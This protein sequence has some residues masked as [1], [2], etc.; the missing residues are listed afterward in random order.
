MIMLTRPK[1]LPYTISE[2]CHIFDTKCAHLNYQYLSEVQLKLALC[3]IIYVWNQIGEKG[4]NTYDF[5][6]S[7]SEHVESYIGKI[8]YSNRFVVNLKPGDLF[9]SVFLYVYDYV[10]SLTEN[11]RKEKLEMW[12]KAAK[13]TP[14]YG[15]FYNAN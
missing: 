3:E 4:I 7:L 13:E 15:T 14:V 5:D 1:E 8:R 11:E 9:T 12:N 6:I 2:I 10:A